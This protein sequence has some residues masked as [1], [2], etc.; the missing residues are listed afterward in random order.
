VRIL[1][2]LL[3]ICSASAFAQ[4]K[5]RPYVILVSFDGFRHDYVTKYDLPNFKTF[6]KNGAAAEALIPSFPSKTFPNHYTIVTGL[7]PGNHGLVDNNFYDVQLEVRY[8][9]RE[10]M[11]VQDPHFYGGTPLWQL[12]QQQGLIAA[13]CFW[14]GSEAPVQGEYP[15][16]YFN[17][18]HDLPNEERISR[19]INWLQLPEKKRPQFISLYFS[20]V[21]SQGH[22]TG[23]NSEELIQTVKEADRLLG[24]LMSALKRVKLPVNVILVSDHGMMELKQEDKTWITLSRYFN[25]ADSSL[26]LV[27]SGTHAFVYTPRADSLV[28]VLKAQEENFVVYKKEE[29]PVYWH[30]QHERVGD[31]L[32]LANPGYQL[33]ITQR[34]FGRS[35]VASPVFGVHG[36]DPYAVKDMHGIFYAQGPN[37]KKGKQIPSFENVHIYPLITKILRLKNPAIDGDGKVLEVIYKN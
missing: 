10:R 3:L 34:N 4:E 20:L 35:S 9:M 32:I 23:P 24:S 25:T 21:D 16:Y 30:Y 36:Y 11:L 19:V 29:T 2:L 12:A 17:Y 15:T 8:T 5:E 26:I 7:Y 13:S 18:E 28:R 22:A 27:N 6:I 31:V 1:F 14:V 33:Q 37:I